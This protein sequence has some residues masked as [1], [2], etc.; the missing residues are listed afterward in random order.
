M[1]ERGHP[2]QECR[3]AGLLHGWNIG[4]RGGARPSPEGE[5]PREN[6]FHLEN[7]LEKTRALMCLEG[8]LC[9]SL[10]R[11]W[12]PPTGQHVVRG[13]HSPWTTI[14]REVSLGPNSES[15]CQ[16]LLEGGYA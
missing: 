4:G 8:E 1:A 11:A 14:L 7:S 13:T 6:W 12:W 15:L 16:T 10:V 9:Y 2:V 3:C 5:D